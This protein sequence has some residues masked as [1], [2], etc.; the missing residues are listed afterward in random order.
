MDGI[1]LSSARTTIQLTDLPGLGPKSVAALRQ[2]GIETVA[3]LHAAGAIPV[4]LRL[5]K[6]LN[7][8]PSLN[9]LY[10]LVG[11][12]EGVHWLS[13]AKNERW[14]LLMA[15]EGYRELEALLAAEQSKAKS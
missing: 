8:A 6:Q 1:E 10:A 4:F 3:E 13:V 15:L 14:Q 2:I 12:I 11:A 7:P 9:F 5:K